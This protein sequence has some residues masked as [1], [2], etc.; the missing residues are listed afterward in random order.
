MSDD[1]GDYTPPPAGFGTRRQSVD[2]FLGDKRHTFRLT[3]GGAEELQ[4]KCDAGPEHLRERFESGSWRIRD[5]TETIRIGL[6]GGGAEPE[7]AAALVGRY[8][9]KRPWLESVPVAHGV[10]LAALV[11]VED[12]PEKK[13]QGEA[14]PDPTLSPEEK[15][16]S[17][18]STD[19]A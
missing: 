16:G 12:E 9:A 3:I 17:E 7:V 1:P 10:L 5:L 8:V 14:A 18:T 2:L 15:S 4:E 13:E 11:G 19:K 6:I